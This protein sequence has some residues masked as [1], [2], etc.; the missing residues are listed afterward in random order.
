[1]CSHN[2]QTM[3]RAPGKLNSASFPGFR[4]F[5]GASPKFYEIGSNIWH[6]NIS[7]SWVRLE[8]LPETFL[9]CWK[10]KDAMWSKLGLELG[11]A[12]A[13]WPCQLLV[14]WS[15]VGQWTSLK[16]SFF[17]YKIHSFTALIYSFHLFHLL[18]PALLITADTQWVI[19]TY[20]HHDKCHLNSGQWEFPS[21][22][23]GIES[24]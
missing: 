9:Q 20:W 18:I 3:H 16:V 22:L 19:T 24:D 17:I 10:Q 14:T 5:Q 15:W 2:S 23:R 6:R 7:I 12:V 11:L 21:W 13:S 8:I 1:M 4:L